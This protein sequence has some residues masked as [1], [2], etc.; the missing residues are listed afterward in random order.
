VHDRAFT[1]TVGR[2]AGFKGCAV[3]MIVGHGPLVI[4]VTGRSGPRG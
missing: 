4:R 2:L 1:G 3:R